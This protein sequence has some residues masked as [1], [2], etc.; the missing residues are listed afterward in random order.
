MTMTD[1]LQLH[2]VGVR[3]GGRQLLQDVTFALPLGQHLCVLGPNGSGKTT[4]LHLLSTYRHPTSGTMQVLGVTFGQADLRELRPTIGFVS[5]AL[6]TLLHGSATA[7]ELVAVARHGGT[8]PPKGLL[9][10]PVLYAQA[11]RA[12]ARVGALHLADRIMQTLSQGERQRVRIARALVIDPQLVLL[13]EPFAGL[14]LGGREALLRDLDALLAEDDAPSVV[15]VTHHLE[16]LPRGID[17]V[18][19]LKEGMI[20]AAGPRQQTLTNENLS[21]TF[22]LPIVVRE[23]DGRYVA[24]IEPA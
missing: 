20:V 11:D 24:M 21:L 5:N 10:D 7:R 12:L 15:L 18:L 6:D 3:K 17:N 14:D 4:L 19:L 9:D 16:E 1:V 2:A 8:W 22:S 13:D 23:Y